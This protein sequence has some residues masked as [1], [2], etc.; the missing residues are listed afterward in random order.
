MPVLTARFPLQGA[1]Q[2][3]PVTGLEPD[4][5]RSPQTTP[6][7]EL[8]T[9]AGTRAESK[10][11]DLGKSTC[12]LNDVSWM[13]DQDKSEFFKVLATADSTQGSLLVMSG[14]S[15]GVQKIG[16][17]WLSSRQ[18]SYSLFHCSGHRNIF[19]CQF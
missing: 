18:M 11:I 14:E 7:R 2:A 6:P 15:Y 4:M 17:G 16:L 13:I 10:F 5:H 9:P 1:E 19:I 3:L 12:L 8:L